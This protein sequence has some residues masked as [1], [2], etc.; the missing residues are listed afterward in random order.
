MTLA[1][2]V[3]GFYSA[4]WRFLRIIIAA[5]FISTLNP[6]VGTLPPTPCIT[7]S[8][9]RSA[10]FSLGF[11]PMPQ[12]CGAIPSIWLIV[13]PFCS[14]FHAHRHTGMTVS[15]TCR[16]TSGAGVAYTHDKVSLQGIFQQPHTLQ[17]RPHRRHRQ[18]GPA[19]IAR[20]EQFRHHIN[21]AYS[22]A[23]KHGIQHRCFRRCPPSPAFT[24]NTS[25]LGVDGL[26]N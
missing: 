24:S 18:S 16:V 8:A 14:R 15:A 11:R 17:G 22:Q 12:L 9:P 20:R 26:C 4:L 10:C 23:Y 13:S 19:D 6:Y 25:S 21:E 3:D 2:L 1:T 5:V 7:S